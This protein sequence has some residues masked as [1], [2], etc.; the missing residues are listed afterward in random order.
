M[1]RRRAIVAALAAAILAP[2]TGCVNQPS[3]DQANR[4]AMLGGLTRA[5]FGTA[6]LTARRVARGEDADVTTASASVVTGRKRALLGVHG[7]ACPAGRL[8]HIRL[9]GSFPHTPEVHIEGSDVTAA[10]HGEDLV[11]VASS[12]R[13]CAH[14]Y[15]TGNIVTDLSA[16]RLF[17]R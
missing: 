3:A 15:L 5:E 17:S 4:R 11:A 6:L 13:V 2:V 8:L 1:S 16:V 10:V 9:V 12:G 7:H 14:S